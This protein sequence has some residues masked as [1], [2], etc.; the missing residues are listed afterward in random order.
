M[1]LAAVIL[2]LNEEKHI[3]RCIRGLNSVVDKIYVVDAYSKDGTVEIAKNLGAIVIQNKWKNHA[4]QFNWALKNIDND[5]AWVLRV[6]AD[7]YLSDDLKKEIATKFSRISNEVSGITVKRKIIFQGKLV[8]FGGVGSINCLRII[9]L[10]YGQCEA[11]LMD[12]HLVV[13]GK[14]EHFSGCIY[15]DNLNTLDWWIEKHNSYAVKE[16]IEAL[17]IEYKFLKREKINRFS[18]SFNAKLKRYLKENIYYKIPINF[19]ASIYY[20]IRNILLC[21]FLDLIQ[22]NKFHFLQGYWYRSQV[23]LKISEIKHYKNINAISIT[24]AIESIT[25]EKVVTEDIN[26]NSC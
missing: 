12:E 16:A 18:Q 5:I 20:I 7:E 23:D 4:T 2:T 8:R 10:G 15:D 11:R 22:G 3:K 6:D 19:R 1:K 13:K 17:N 9:K 26:N 14:I 25:G 24:D 21:G